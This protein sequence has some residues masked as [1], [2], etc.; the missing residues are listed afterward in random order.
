M[1]YRKFIPGQSHKKKISGKFI[2]GNGQPITAIKMGRNE[3]CSCG[4]GKKV[5]HCHGSKTLYK[6]TNKDDK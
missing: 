3:P 4:S 5:K 6:N 1:K 2:E